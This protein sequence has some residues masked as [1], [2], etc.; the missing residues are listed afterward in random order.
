MKKKAKEQ[1]IKVNICLFLTIIYG[2]I[3][4]SKSI[5]YFKGFNLLS[6]NI[7]FISDEGI[8]KYV[9]ENDTKILVH[10]FNLITSET[11]LD[12]ISFAQFPLDEGGHVF[13]RIKEYIYIYDEDLN[14]Y[15]GNISIDDISNKYCSLVPYKTKNG[16]ITL[17]ISHITGDQKIKQIIYQINVVDQQNIQGSITITNETEVIN[18]NGE[19]EKVIINAISCELISSL[20]Y[21]NKLLACFVVKQSSFSIVAVIFNPENSLSFLYISNNSKKTNGLSTIYS[22]LDTNKKFSLICFVDNY[23][24]FYC[25]IYNSYKNIFNDIVQLIQNCKYQLDMGVKYISDKQEYSAYCSSDS[26]KMNLIIFDQ[27]FNIK[28]SDENNN[29]CYKYFDLINDE[30]NT[31]YSYN[32]LYSKNYQK[33]YVFR[34]C[35]T[36]NEEVFTLLI[37]LFP[38]KDLLLF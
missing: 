4:S 3:I 13:C 6:N 31:L 26:N 25:L 36:N 34:A 16:I 23:G 32:M 24:Y 14:N 29:K 7:L 35:F 38:K 15:F 33:F 11:D 27:N 20:D 22:T 37:F 1:K 8:I 12:Y 19:S 18:K 5:K 2:L 21:S 17:I 9:P 30:C 10:P 28:Y